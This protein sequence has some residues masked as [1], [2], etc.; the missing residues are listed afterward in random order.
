MA[1]TGESSESETGALWAAVVPR[2]VPRGPNR[3]T[4]RSTTAAG[5]EAVARRGRF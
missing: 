1:S 3:L 5:G 4:T 2:L